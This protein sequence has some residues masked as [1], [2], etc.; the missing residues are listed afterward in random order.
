MARNGSGVREATKTSYEI[1]FVYQRERCRERIKLKP[2]PS[3]RRIVERHRADIIAAIEDGTFDYAVTFPNS[4]RAKAFQESQKVIFIGQWLDKWLDHKERHIK[5][6]TYSGYRKAIGILKPQF[7]HIA[8][9]D[10]KKKDVRDWC[11]TLDCSNKR[12]RNLIQP[13]INAMQYAVEDELIENNPLKDF[14]FK[15]IEPPKEDYVD[16]LSR[17]EAEKLLSVL[18]GQYKNLIQF[19]LW[20]GLRT[21]ELIALQWGDVDFMRGVVRIQRAKTQAS[22]KFE[23]TKTNAGTREVKLLAPALSALGAQKAHTF[24]AGQHI[25]IN[26]ANGKPYSGDQQLWQAWK[27]A[28]LRAGIRYRPPY[29][30]RHTFASWMLSA[31]ESLPWISKQLGHASMQVTTKHYARFITD[32]QPEA[33][34]KAVDLFGV[35]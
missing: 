8:L 10:I 34:N 24:L 27:R 3:N 5:A 19:A 32:S 33:G 23:T 9:T 28:L 1:E 29:H 18:N 7:G 17:E 13:L 11:K 15:R 22:R 4:K 6:S 2:C 12:V 21:S 20:T 26:E 30:T 35:K 31:G 14:S 16:P 25:F